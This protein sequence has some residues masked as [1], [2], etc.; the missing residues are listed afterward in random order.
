MNLRTHQISFQGRTIQLTL[1]PSFTPN[2]RKI[3]IEAAEGSAILCGLELTN[4]THVWHLTPPIPK[5]AIG[6]EQQILQLLG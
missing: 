5:W 6:F 2:S 3:Y 4:R 1:K